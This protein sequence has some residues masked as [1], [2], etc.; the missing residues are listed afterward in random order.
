MEGVLVEIE[1]RLEPDQV[2]RLESTFD[3][4]RELA[5]RNAASTE[6]AKAKEPSGDGAAKEWDEDS[7][8]LPGTFG[9]KSALRQASERLDSARRQASRGNSAAAVRDSIGALSALQ[10]GGWSIWSG[11]HSHL[12]AE[13]IISANVQGADELARAYGPLLLDEKYNQRWM[14]ANHIISLVGSRLD[15]AGQAE[16]LSVAIDHVRH[17]V[18]AASPESFPYIGSDSSDSATDALIEL[19]LWAIDHPSWERR[20]SAAAMMLWC[21]RCDPGWSSAHEAQVPLSAATHA[22]R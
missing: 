7:L 16:L 12:E 17:L 19:L 6:P 14:V 2:S 18:G 21:A 11:N 9:K 15:P 20:D 1:A 3:V 4:K 22:H 8:Y 10:D 13:T 5:A